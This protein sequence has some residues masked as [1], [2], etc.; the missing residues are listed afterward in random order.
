MSD[1]TEE[2]EHPRAQLPGICGFTQVTG[3]TEWICVKRIHATEK[4]VRQGRPNAYRHVFVNRWPN[5]QRT[6]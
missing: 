1:L 2:D 6:A 4:D 5:R 3:Q